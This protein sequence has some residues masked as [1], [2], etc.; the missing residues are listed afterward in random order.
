MSK[1]VTHVL[2]ARLSY[3][4]HIIL[5]VSPQ[6]KWT[7]RSLWLFTLRMQFCHFQSL[8]NCVRLYEMFYPVEFGWAFLH[9]SVQTNR[10]GFVWKP[11]KTTHSWPTSAPLVLHCIRVWLLRAHFPKLN[12]LLEN[13]LAVFW[14]CCSKVWMQS[15]SLLY[16]ASVWSNTSTAPFTTT[17]LLPITVLSSCA[18]L[19]VH[20]MS[21]WYT[22]KTP[23]SKLN[24]SP[25]PVC[26][27]C[28]CRTQRSP[29]WRGTSET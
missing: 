15:L 8:Q 14:N 12:N 20:E 16:R 9:F 23:S 1:I 26:C 4:H 27:C 21:F 22:E 3:I 18:S 2:H 7:R 6:T 24:L 29:P 10:S 28:C 25:L 5:A 13:K 11:V 19:L 17:T